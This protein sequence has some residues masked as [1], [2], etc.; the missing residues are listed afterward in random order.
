MENKVPSRLVCMLV[1]LLLPEELPQPDGQLEGRHPHG[2]RRARVERLQVARGRHH[3]R[4]EGGRK[5]NVDE[6]ITL[7][8]KCHLR[9]MSHKG[10]YKEG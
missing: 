4:T 1:L 10:G 5:Q 8:M 9:N 2:G 6:I 3:A 7:P